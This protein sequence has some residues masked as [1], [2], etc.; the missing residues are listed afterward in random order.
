M[1]AP[2]VLLLLA[3]LGAAA[4]ADGL[5]PADAEPHWIWSP[6]KATNGQSV[7][8]R[9]TFSVGKRPKTATLS[10][11]A[12][13]KVSVW[14][15]GTKVLDTEG[16]GAAR[17]AD[18][19]ALAGGRNKTLAVVGTNADGP[20]GV[21]VVLDLSYADGTKK[22]VISDG[23]WKAAPADPAGG[24]GWTTPGFA[25]AAN[26]QNA[27]DLGPVGVEPWGAIKYGSDLPVPTAT[28]AE[29]LEVA[30]GYA[31]ELLYSVPKETQGSWV[32][33]TAAPN[34][35]LVVSDQYGKLYRV[36]PPAAGDEGA[37][38]EVTPI[39]V[40]V[41]MAQGLLCVGD[42]LYV[43]VNDR[44]N[45][46]LY[47]VTDSDGDG[48]WDASELLQ[49][50]DGNGEHGPH[51]VRLD[52]ADP[53][54]LWV[55]AGNHTKPPAGFDRGL[56]PVKNYREDLLLPRNP[57]GNGHAT[58]RLAPAGWVASCDLDGK[59]WRLF[60]A[61]FRNPYDIAFDAAGE[62]FTFDADMEWD[63]GTPWY[64]PTRLN[65]VVSGGEY[66]WRFGT[67]KWPEYYA[68]SVGGVVDLGLGSPTGVE[69]AAG[70]DF[71]D[72]NVLFLAD[73]THGRVF[74]ATL[75]PDGASY[76]ASFRTF[77]SGRPLPVTDLCAN[78]HD[79]SLYVTTGGR[80][81]QSGLYRV[82]YTGEA[83]PAGAPP[84]ATNEVARRTRHMLE[85]GHTGEPADLAALW[86]HLGSPDRSIRYAAR[87]AL[88]RH[89]ARNWRTR[90][91]HETRP[92]AIVQAAVALA[93]TGGQSDRSLL[94]DKLNGLNFAGLTSEQI[95][96]AARAYQLALIRL[97]GHP[98]EAEAEALAAQFIGVAP[99]PDERVNREAVRLLT[100]L[101]ATPPVPAEFARGVVTLAMNRLAVASTQGDQ[102]FYPFILRNLTGAVGPVD[103]G[104]IRDVLRLAEPGR[105]RGPR[106]ELLQEVR[107]PDSG[108]RGEEPAGRPQGRV[109]RR[110]RDAGPAGGRSGGD[111]AAVRG[112][113]A[114]AGLRRPERRHDRPRPGPR[115]GRVRS[116]E[117]R[118]V[119]PVRRRRRG[120]GAGPD[121]RRRPV[122]RPLSVGSH[123]R[124]VQGRVGSIPGG[125]DPDG[126]RPRV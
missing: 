114:D 61:G 77:L 3:P 92:N 106:G 56:S 118:P 120:D 70:T 4:P 37:E 19:T 100:Y 94:L 104:S 80:R 81:T 1:F 101:A 14:L 44:N 59:N 27:K 46:G 13:D 58:G 97:G 79:G 9:T 75:K 84:S 31:V 95:L 109:E 25:G 119:P 108:G 60:A 73:W 10:V 69:F 110:D 30:D 85:R 83:S 65:H 51:A 66:G 41:G 87:V 78:P 68:D 67:G 36:T 35:D 72:Q 28:P 88:E 49:K 2:A 43:V 99:H 102:M 48:A 55:V 107:G 6:G 39:A 121:R 23:S 26:W 34:G 122:R 62:L 18:V 24:T 103:G 52:P 15:G 76:T 7:R 11:A 33:M 89:P 47:K 54:R 111:H 20:A 112:E 74:E 105:S 123:S 117:V 71:P 124:T 64:R 126:G 53:T 32:A 5:S 86:P 50:L 8:L 115:P 38:L 16:W 12:D 116:G 21:L 96:D 93:R 98:A 125:A 63:T 90:F 22:R 91:G 29:K 82:R 113:L 42:D 45:S 40:E 17:V 57:D